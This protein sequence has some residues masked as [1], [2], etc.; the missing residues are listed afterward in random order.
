MYVCMHVY[1]IHTPAITLGLDTLAIT[2]VDFPPAITLG[3]DTLGTVRRFSSLAYRKVSAT[4]WP[5]LTSKGK[6]SM[7]VKPCA[8]YALSKRQPPQSFEDACGDHHDAEAD[9]RAVAVILFDSEQFGTRSLYN[10]TFKSSKKCFQPLKAV[11]ENM[12]VKMQDP[13]I[14]IEPL[15][16]GW[17]SAP[18]SPSPYIIS[19]PF[20]Y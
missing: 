6:P 10:C 16:R 9:T 5:E 13:V 14:D 4:D 15:P 18:V 20:I 7:G 19:L 17:V 3:L 8:I 11:W 2:Q 1:L 12:C